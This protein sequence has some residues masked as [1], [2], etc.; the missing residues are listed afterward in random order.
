MPKS[1]RSRS[2][3]TLIEV[4]VAV[5]IV[6]VVIGALFSMQG[7]ITHKYFSAQEMMRTNQYSSFLLSGDDTYGFDKSNIDM[8]R[9]VDEFELESDLRRKLSAIKVNLDYEEL[10]TIDTNE[11]DAD[12]QTTDTTQEVSGGA[13]VVF[14][15]G[16]TILKT[17]AFTSSLIRVRIQ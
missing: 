14:E 17:D 2:A 3:F 15:I 11:L 12:T 9:L 5:M 1:K 16:K 7:N 13:G 4:M 10:S 6:S 8:K